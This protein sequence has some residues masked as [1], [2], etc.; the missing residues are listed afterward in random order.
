MNLVS[1]QHRLARESFDWEV[2]KARGKQLC[3]QTR[4]VGHIPTFD[5]SLIR[6]T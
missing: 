4:G 5:A 1:A 3:S 2:D 6:L